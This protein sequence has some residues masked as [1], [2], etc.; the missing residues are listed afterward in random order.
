[1]KRILVLA[2]LA[3]LVAATGAFAA[4]GGGQE[5]YR[6]W[7][8]GVQGSL[9]KLKVDPA[10]A[11][12]NGIVRSFAV[13]YFDATCAGGATVTLRRARLRGEIPVG[14]GG[15]F[16]ERDDNGAT[17]FKVRG[18]LGLTNGKARGTFRY[19]GS[20]ETPNGVA[21][22]CDSGRLRWKARAGG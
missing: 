16:G 15:G 10:D 12:S 17:V 9:V 22:N 4:R 8:P 5:Q 11:N 6:G 2:M 14:H 20:I 3:T 18:K 1:M 19:F 21:R 7:L 13:R